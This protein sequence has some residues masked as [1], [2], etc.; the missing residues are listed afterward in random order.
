MK[1]LNKVNKNLLKKLT[2]KLGNLRSDRS[3]NAH[4]IRFVKDKI[5]ELNSMS[6]NK[7]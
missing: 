3:H 6:N 7:A 1:T 2:K 4:Q 5:G